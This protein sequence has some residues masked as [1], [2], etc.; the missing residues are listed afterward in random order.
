MLAGQSAHAGHWTKE[1]L[2]HF[3]AP[4]PFTPL[5]AREQPVEGRGTGPVT[6]EVGASPTVHFGIHP[7]KCPMVGAARTMGQRLPPPRTDP[8]AKPD[9][10]QPRLSRCS[11][12]THWTRKARAAARC[13]SVDF[14]QKCS[15][16]R[17]PAGRS[18]FARAVAR[19]SLPNP[20][21]KRSGARTGT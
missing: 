5:S 15:A 16:R 10:E 9:L 8:L 2:N 19:A 12:S 7:G 1:A 4:D 20:E 21:S 13:I 14:E 11:H 6:P 17:K 18:V 3:D